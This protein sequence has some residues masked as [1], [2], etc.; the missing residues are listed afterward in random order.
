M[1]TMNGNDNRTLRVRFKDVKGKVHDIPAR[2]L[3][4]SHLR[5]DGG[6]DLRFE[7]ETQE[8]AQGFSNFTATVTAETA[9]RVLAI[10]R[11]AILNR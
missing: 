2:N 5:E 6:Y 10:A 4:L 8:A 1:T 9:A 7:S 11:K 3:L